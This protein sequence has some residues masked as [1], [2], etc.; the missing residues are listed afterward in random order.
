MF[1]QFIIRN[2]NHFNK[3]IVKLTKCYKYILDINKLCD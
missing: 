1:Y 3:K 2:D